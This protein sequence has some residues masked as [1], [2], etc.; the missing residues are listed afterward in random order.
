M[1]SSTSASSNA[2]VSASGRVERSDAFT[3]GLAFSV[4]RT[5]EEHRVNGA[6]QWAEERA[7]L[8]QPRLIAAGHI[9]SL[10]RRLNAEVRSAD[11]WM[12]SASTFRCANGITAS[13]MKIS[14][15]SSTASRTRSTPRNFASD[16]AAN[17]SIRKTEAAGRMDAVVYDRTLS[18]CSDGRT[19]MA[20]RLRDQRD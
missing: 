12:P 1:A 13:F 19:L 9:R 8:P 11:S 17:A 10:S 7:N 18:A 20:G 15:G 5:K 4:M 2:A 3:S 14:G 16:S 6:V